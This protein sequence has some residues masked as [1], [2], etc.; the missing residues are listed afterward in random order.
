MPKLSF[1]NRQDLLY[2]IGQSDVLFRSTLNFSNYNS[3]RSQTIYRQT[4]LTVASERYKSENLTTQVPESSQLEGST[5]MK[6]PAVIK[7]KPSKKWFGIIPNHLIKTLES[8]NSYEDRIQALKEISDLYVKDP[9]N[10]SVLS[11]KIN[12][13]IEYMFELS[14]EEFEVDDESIT[15]EAISV[16]HE[17]LKK[18][19]KT[20]GYIK[21]KPIF[22][23]LIE[24]S[25]TRDSLLLKEVIQIFKQLK[26]ILGETDYN[27]YVHEFMYDPKHSEI[28][29]SLQ[30][31][32]RESNTKWNKSKGS[33]E[34]NKDLTKSS[35]LKSKELS[36]IVQTIQISNESKARNESK[37]DRKDAKNKKKKL[38]LSI[39][40][41]SDAENNKSFSKG[42][43]GEAFGFRE[44]KLRDSKSIMNRKSDLLNINAK[45]NISLPLQSPLNGK[46]I[47]SNI[48]DKKNK[49]ILTV[50]SSLASLGTTA[51]KDEALP[52]LK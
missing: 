26:R 45:S 40:S 32:F 37:T 22:S 1:I 12:E 47:K 42:D 13:F 43:G 31:I 8:Y 44:Y 23:N 38:N 6:T 9:N 20:F 28:Q 5:T 10:F 14:N 11:K 50:H 29:E 27:N 33:Q 48:T 7:S 18:D 16:I 49:N 34:E 15:F 2:V 46:G 52:P 51:T 35:D 41:E 39:I 19:P 30:T 17:I 25:K 21:F 36:N 24:H 3:I 4:N